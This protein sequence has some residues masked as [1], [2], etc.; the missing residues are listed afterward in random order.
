MSLRRLIL[1]VLA[2][3]CM[4]GPAAAGPLAGAVAA[5][6]GMIGAAGAAIGASTLLT[7]L[8]FSVAASALAR[9]LAPKPD[10]PS[11]GIRTKTTMAGGTQP[12]T[13]IVGI[14]A[15]AGT[16]IA[17]PYSHGIAGDGDEVEHL[18]IAYNLADYP[19]DGLQGVIVDGKECVFNIPS[20]RDGGIYG[21]TCSEYD[22]RAWLRWHDGRQS[23]PDAMLRA[24]Y[25][26]HP[27]RP[28]GPDAIL[29]GT[30]YG[31]LTYKWDREVWTG[32]P[33]ARFI[34]RGARLYDPRRDSTVAGGSGSQRWD[35]PATWAFTENPIVI[36]YNLFRGIRLADGT[37]YGLKVRAR[38]LPPAVWAAAMNKCDE[39]V[40]V[41]GGGTRTRYRAG[42][43]FAVSDE[44]LD[45]IEIIGRSCGADFAEEGGVWSVDVGAPGGVSAWLTDD[46]LVVEAEDS[47]DPF[48]VLTE[49]YTG[50][51]ATFPNPARLW[52]S[53]EASPYYNVAYETAAGG[54][55]L[56]A[57]LELSAVSDRRQVRAV[58]REYVR[59]A[60][61]GRR[62]IITLPPAYLYLPPL[63]T[64]S[65]T[66]TTRGFTAKR[67]EIRSK[68]IDP[69]T[70]CVTLGLRERDP[71]DYDP[72]A[73]EDD[74][75][76]SD[77]N[78]TKDDR[79]RVGVKGLALSTPLIGRRA[80][81]RAVWDAEIAAQWVRVQARH[82]ATGNEVFDRRVPAEDG[83]LQWT[84]GLQPLTAYEVRAKA[85]G[86][87]RGDWSA[88]ATVTTDDGRLVAD[89][90]AL[91]AIAP[92]HLLTS[93]Y[94]NL[95]PDNQMQDPAGWY[96]GA[97]NWT[98]VAAAGQGSASIGAWRANVGSGDCYLSGSPFPVDPDSD[99]VV[100]Y[101]LRRVG[102]TMMRAQAHVRWYDSTDA[103]LSTSSV[104]YYDGT[105]AVTLRRVGRVT[106]APDA[107]LARLRLIVDQAGT[108]GG[109]RFTGTYMRR[110][111]EN[112]DIRDGAI[113]RDYYETQLLT[114]AGSGATGAFVT[115]HAITVA[116]P[117][118]GARVEVQA[119][120]GTRNAAGGAR[121]WDIGI[122]YGAANDWV[123]GA[124]AASEQYQ[125]TIPIA[126]FI[127]F[128]DEGT[129]TFRLR[130]KMS[131]DMDIIRDTF[132]VKLRL[133]K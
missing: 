97:G 21:P 15:T 106:S 31:V 70:L 66:S 114:V 17:P 7:N 43:E 126:G 128:L 2:L 125:A 130:H 25:G 85:V 103:F 71:S 62:A 27:L 83:R 120:V 124:R 5:I 133:N 67:F 99:Y 22:D 51:H 6:G 102:G 111:A 40:A 123:P 61:R 82:A 80:G 39:T 122:Q 60:Q 34:V 41:A 1:P 54:R 36:C 4:A 65:W 16:L 52:E 109:V 55:R 101:Q 119:V 129:Y 50:A 74:R 115:Y 12:Q 45:V 121:T 20:T 96:V 89:D 59:D 84:A 86:R 44:P 37:V 100:R 8:V 58:T 94:G 26:D 98:P 113:T 110:Q 11:G 127:P 75:R 24:V 68:R 63:Q 131:T 19:I 77:P 3:V 90:V 46:D 32:L 118:G 35:D 107:A 69:L 88:W 132:F 13:I 108:D 91:M 92:R 76:P 87:R 105:A 47:D 81:I 48:A 112:E 57:D 93:D 9:A 29:T 38:Q 104:G 72:D 42:L 78:A 14:T 79:V 95:I 56:V 116:I 73:L 18:V 117:P 64:V 53:A 33:A 30:A 28:W 49:T 23:A 10:M